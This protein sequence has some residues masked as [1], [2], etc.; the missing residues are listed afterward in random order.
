[1]AD[2]APTTFGPNDWLVDEM[3]EQFER[4]PSSVSESWRDF[5]G[6]DNGAEPRA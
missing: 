5:F 1:M 4:D 3:R 2:D 6:D